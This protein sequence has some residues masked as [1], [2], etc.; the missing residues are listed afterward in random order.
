MERIS[1]KM[2]FHWFSQAY[3]LAKKIHLPDFLLHRVL[4]LAFEINVCDHNVSLSR[5]R[6]NTTCGSFQFHIWPSFLYHIMLFSSPLFNKLVLTLTVDV[7]LQSETEKQIINQFS[8]TRFYN[9]SDF[10]L[11]INQNV[12]IWLEK[13][14][15]RQFVSFWWEIF[16]RRQ[17]SNSKFYNGSHFETK[18]CQHEIWDSE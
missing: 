5:S 13:L 2:K 14:S 6:G 9:L 12:W 15:T 7:I 16:R 4:F 17:F 10:Q 3:I 18:V 8:K 11:K 1:T